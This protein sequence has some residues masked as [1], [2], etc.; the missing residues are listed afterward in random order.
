MIGTML[1]TNDRAPAF[2]LPD[3]DGNIRSLSEYAGTWL[4]LYFY[5]KDDTPGC[6][7][8]ACS[9]RDNLSALKAKG[10]TIIGVSTDSV[11]SHRKFADKHGLPF[12]LLA[13]EKKEAVSAYGLWAEKSMYGKKYMGTLRSSFLIRPDGTIAK[14]YEKVKPGEHAAEILHDMDDMIS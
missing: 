1:Q 14:I 5:P 7:E 2:S 9:L 10:L 3:Q 4:L 11:A 6:T 8:E 13:D 12:T